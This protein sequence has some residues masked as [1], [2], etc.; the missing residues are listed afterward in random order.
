[1][2]QLLSTKNDIPENL[3]SAKSKNHPEAMKTNSQKKSRIVLATS[4]KKTKIKNTRNLVLVPVIG[5]INTK[6]VAHI[7]NL[8][9]KRRSPLRSTRKDMTGPLHDVN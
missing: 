5:S 9:E 1:M 3:E 2:I 4:T 7:L 8:P 6:I